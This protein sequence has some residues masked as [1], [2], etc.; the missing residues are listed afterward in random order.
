MT[1][2]AI[3]A[4]ALA[5]MLT[6]CGSPAA[7][8]IE[9]PADSAAVAASAV[10]AAAP[11][12][13]PPDAAR[14]ILFVGT[15]L[16][17]GYGVGPDSAYPAVIQQWLDSAGLPYRVNNAGLS[18]ETSAGGL[19]RMA[20]SL[21]AP[22]DV[23]V[24]ELGANDGLRGTPPEYLRANLDSIIRLTRARYPQSAIVLAGMEAPPNLGDRYTGAFRKV[25]PELARKYHAALVPFLLAGV[26]AVDSLNQ[27]DGIHPNAAGH[28][29][30]AANVWRVLEPLL[31]ARAQRASS[32]SR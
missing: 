25:F 12:P 7:R 8:P 24:L 14:V 15:S 23:L 28:R 9:R 20:W 21:Q 30:V 13:R 18:G 17:A 16:T 32:A 3:I 31:R 6:A 22:M 27:A 5:A 26:A 2:R 19:S 29:I 11:A 4:G 1:M 10:Q